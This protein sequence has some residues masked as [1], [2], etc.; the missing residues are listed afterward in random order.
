MRE[1]IM[2]RHPDKYNIPTTV[3]TKS[4]VQS[5]LKKI[6]GEEGKQK[7]MKIANKQA[8]KR[9]MRHQRCQNLYRGRP[10]P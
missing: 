1:K 10:V 3:L 2:K 9:S 8:R 5:R 6:R 7:Q 4:V